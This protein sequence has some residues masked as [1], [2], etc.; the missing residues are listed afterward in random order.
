VAAWLEAMRGV[1]AHDAAFAVNAALGPLADGRA[2]TMDRIKGANAAAAQAIAAEDPRS[3]ID[4]KAALTPPEGA[5]D[6]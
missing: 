6:E 4:F 3:S 2:V 5:E 1:D